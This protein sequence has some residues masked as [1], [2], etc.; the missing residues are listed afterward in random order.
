MRSFQNKATL[1]TG[2]ASG[3]GRE[4]A[5][6]M[7]N[8]GA[9]LGLLDRNEE[10]L[11]ELSIE[12]SKKGVENY[13]IICDLG[14]QNSIP[15]IKPVVERHLGNLEILINNAG[16]GLHGPTHELTDHERN[17]VL[18][19]NLNAPFQLFQLFIHE[20]L[21]ANGGQVVN[22]SSFLG[23]VPQAQTTA[24]SVSK[25]GLV[26]L[27]E[28]LRAEYSRWGLGVT[29]ICPG[30]VQTP[31]IENLPT[32][33]KNG[34][35]LKHPPKWLTT[36]P[37]KIASQTVAAMKRNR[38]LV[39]STGLAKFLYTAKRLLPGTF[40]F[41]QTFQ[42]SKIKRL[43]GFGKSTANSDKAGSDP[44]KDFENPDLEN[45]DLENSRHRRNAA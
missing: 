38:R 15:F 41:I 26:G 37:Q 4:I 35:K 23:L 6:Q 16:I 39:V 29:L 3:I 34:Q 45:P 18:Q 2:A 19:V 14:D 8:Q 32:V 27:T 12:L 21:N 31:L 22:V 1:I 11:R 9:R 10:S 13:P 40:D 5:I 25:Y 7:G 28:S 20:L 36:T 24:Y 17:H 43:L 30:F 42:S 44:R 33:S